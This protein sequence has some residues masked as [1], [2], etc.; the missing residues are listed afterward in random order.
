MDNL[1]AIKELSSRLYGKN[2][3]E[4]L[5]NYAKRYGVADFSQL[6][7]AQLL[8]VKQGLERVES[9]VTRYNRGRNY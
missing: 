3:A 5:Q 9:R 4:V 6:T 2:Q 7:A 8:E 1:T